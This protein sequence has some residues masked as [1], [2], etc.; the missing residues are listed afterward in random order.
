MNEKKIKNNLKNDIDYQNIKIITINISTLI[1]L[2][3]YKK[4]ITEEEFESAI[5]I[6]SKFYEEKEDESIRKIID[7]GDDKNE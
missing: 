4:I 3:I 7:K 6:I 5:G 1:Q 2:L